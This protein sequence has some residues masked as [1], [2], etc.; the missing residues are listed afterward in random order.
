MTRVIEC[1]DC[2]SLIRVAPGQRFRVCPVCG[3]PLDRGAWEGAG[4]AA[5]VSVVL[6]AAGLVLFAAAWVMSK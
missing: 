3:T 4:A 5:W 1:G 6:A 2:R